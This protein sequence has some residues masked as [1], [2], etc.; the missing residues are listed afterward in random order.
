MSTKLQLKNL[1][2]A[3]EIVEPGTEK[4]FEH[5]LSLYCSTLILSTVN[6]ESW[7]AGTNIVPYFSHYTR[8]N[9]TLPLNMLM[10]SENSSYSM[11]WC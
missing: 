7:L 3:K 10:N 2:I 1:L 4:V 6:V 8:V 9:D 5:S 11:P